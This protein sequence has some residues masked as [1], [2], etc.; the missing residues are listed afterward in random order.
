M[1]QARRR[2]PK[3]RV[4]YRVADLLE[5]PRDLE[6]SFDLVVECYTLQVLP[7][8]ARARAVDALRRTLR[9]GGT[10]LVL[11]RGRHESEPAG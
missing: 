9:P 2:F 1:A 10:L 3:I 8:E 6:D 4:D 7:T 5:L 11:A